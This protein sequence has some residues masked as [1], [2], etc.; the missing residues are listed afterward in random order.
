MSYAPKELLITLRH[1]PYG[2]QLAKEAIDAVLAASVYEQTLSVLFI[3]D[4]VFQLT[5]AQQA[6]KLQQKNIEKMLSAFSLYGIE[7]L[8]VCSQSLQQRGLSIAQLS[9]QPH[10]LT[11]QE[12]HTLMAQQHAIMSF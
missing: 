12:I 3:D 7:R 5:S 1:A 8:Y 9:L 6:D 11:A 2:S 10:P 4:G